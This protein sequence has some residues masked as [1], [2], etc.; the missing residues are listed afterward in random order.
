MEEDPTKAFCRRHIHGYCSIQVYFDEELKCSIHK[1]KEC[2][3][4]IEYLTYMEEDLLHNADCLN[5][6]IFCD[7]IIYRLT[8]EGPGFIP[9]PGF[10]KITA[11]EFY[12]T[13]PKKI[14]ILLKIDDYPETYTFRFGSYTK[15]SE[16]SEQI[17]DGQLYYSVDYIFQ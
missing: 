11:K 6:V 15:N 14:R 13:R 12:F 7:Y 10:I 1:I 9:G 16:L 8:D 5:R 17:I 3:E 2:I 4:C